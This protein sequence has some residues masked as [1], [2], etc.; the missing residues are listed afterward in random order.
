LV[1]D[2]P[3]KKKMDAR[4]QYILVLWIMMDEIGLIEAKE[5]TN[6]SLFLALKRYIGDPHIQ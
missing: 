6:V 2:A 5:N 3:V 4:T 1:H